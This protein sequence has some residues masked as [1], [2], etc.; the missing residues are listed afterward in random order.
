[1]SLPA[2]SQRLHQWTLIWL[3]ALLVVSAA[4]AVIWNTAAPAGADGNGGPPAKP[5]GLS[6]S[7][8]QGSLDV[9]ADWDDVDGAG[10]Y[11]VRWRLSGPDQELNEGV[12]V[13]SSSAA[14]AVD[15]YGECVMRVQ[16]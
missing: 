2:V 12:R 16:A 9:S 13:E 6:V 11:L 3:T 5:T 7:T 8:E 1:M 14:I 15:D 10:E 4:L